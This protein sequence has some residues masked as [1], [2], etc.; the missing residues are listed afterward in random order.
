MHYFRIVPDE[1]SGRYMHT[2]LDVISAYDNGELPM[3]L[4]IAALADVIED[5]VYLHS[6]S[7]VHGD[8]KPLHGLW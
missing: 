6:N 8:I 3:D 4:R 7:V 5:I 1:I 2:F